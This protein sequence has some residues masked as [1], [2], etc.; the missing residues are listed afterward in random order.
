MKN[1]RPFAHPRRTTTA[2]S[3][4]ADHYDGGFMKREVSGTGLS[5]WVLRRAAVLLISSALL[6]PGNAFL[7]AQAAPAPS[8]PSADVKIPAEQ[9]D[10]LV[11][12]IALY[13]DNLL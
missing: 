9:L 3:G 1:L 6:V 7:F 2:R 12:P 5:G 13:P 8:G 10:A 4:T 11:A